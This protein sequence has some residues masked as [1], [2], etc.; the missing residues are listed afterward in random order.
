MET[1]EALGRRRSESGEHR[2]EWPTE[3][4]LPSIPGSSP[5]PTPAKP[6]TP[7][8]GGLRGPFTAPRLSSSCRHR[9][10]PTV[11][12]SPVARSQSGQRS[13]SA[14]PGSCFQEPGC[15]LHA[16]ACSFSRHPPRHSGPRGCKQLLCAP[17]LP[18]GGGFSSWEDHPLSAYV[19]ERL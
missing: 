11:S 2:P 5:P 18:A 7:R 4:P 12:I 15:A 17:R 14:A 13:G 8:I 6:R 16:G 3:V 9:G 1:P 10:G 19:P